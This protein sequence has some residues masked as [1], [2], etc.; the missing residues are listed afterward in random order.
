[1]SILFSYVTEKKDNFFGKKT[2]IYI[3]ITI[4]PQVTN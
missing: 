3:K 4:S 1:M 2:L